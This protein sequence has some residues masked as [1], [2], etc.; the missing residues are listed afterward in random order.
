V[1]SSAMHGESHGFPGEIAAAAEAK[2]QFKL[3]RD[4]DPRFRMSRATGVAVLSLVEGVLDGPPIGLAERAMAKRGADHPGASSAPSTG[5]G[6][7]T[8]RARCLKALLAAVARGDTSAVAAALVQ[9]VDAEGTQVG[10]RQ[11]PFGSLTSNQLLGKV[12][13]FLL[14]EL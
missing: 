1:T 10:C 2:A 6:T 14:F 12:R 13:T 4:M 8:G 11:M 5:K 9:S 3:L 7:A